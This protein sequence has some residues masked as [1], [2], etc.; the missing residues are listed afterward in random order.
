MTSALEYLAYG[1][2]AWM[3]ASLLFT[4]LIARAGLR[5]NKRMARK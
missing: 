4:L 3:T 2:A 1:L 5:F